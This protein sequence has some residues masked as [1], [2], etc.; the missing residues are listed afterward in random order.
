MFMVVVPTPSMNNKAFTNKYIYSF[1]RKIVAN[2][3]K[4]KKK[5]HIVI[6]STV[7]PGSCEEFIFYIE[8]KQVLK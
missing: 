7:M 4:L 8:K 1:L 3:N 2:K 5:F 6:T